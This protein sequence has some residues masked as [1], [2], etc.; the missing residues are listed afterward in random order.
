M[1][2]KE[3]VRILATAVLVAAQM[4]ECA[5]V[6]K[7][8][9]KEEYALEYAGGLLEAIEKGVRLAAKAERVGKTYSTEELLLDPEEYGGS[10]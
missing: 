7:T 10:V 6:N 8:E 3:D 5:V 9:M 2:D 1:M 4:M